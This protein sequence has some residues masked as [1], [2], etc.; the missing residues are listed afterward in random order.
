VNGEAGRIDGSTGGKDRDA[1]TF[2][3]AGPGRLDRGQG[4]AGLLPIV[5]SGYRP[6]VVA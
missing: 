6:L 4:K 1:A 5:T 3:A 2:A